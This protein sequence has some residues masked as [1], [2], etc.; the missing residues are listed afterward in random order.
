[1]G[2]RKHFD[3]G[4]ACIRVV[5]ISLCDHRD[6]GSSAC[7]R[8]LRRAPGMGL[9]LLLHNLPRN[10]VVI[11]NNRATRSSSAR[12][13]MSLINSTLGCEGCSLVLDSSSSLSEVRFPT[14]TNFIA[15]LMRH[16]AGNGT[17]LNKRCM[18]Q[19]PPYQLTSKRAEF[20]IL[21]RVRASVL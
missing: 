4:Y 5:R 6:R 8:L 14:L 15:I 1:M 7:C 12:I 17:A 19:T 20:H 13:Q 21:W 18:R 9:C 16:T 10:P 11:S 3:D 2:G